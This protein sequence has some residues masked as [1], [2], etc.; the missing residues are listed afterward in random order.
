MPLQDPRLAITEMVR[1]V[2][3]LGLHGLAIGTVMG[4]AELDHPELLR[5]AWYH[6]GD[7]FRRDEDGNY[8]F[9]D[10]LRDVIR[11]HGENMS[12]MEI[13]REISAHPGVRQCAVFGVPGVGDEEVMAVIVPTD[14]LRSPLELIEFLVD[15]L[16][17]F[18]IPRY[19]DVADALPTT[20][21][22]RVQKGEL[23]ERGVTATTW[24]REAEGV[25][26][27]RPHLDT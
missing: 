5:N 10:R 26:L 19:I 18:M 21:T 11:R 25:F 13:E 7:A 1:A 16:P 15:R 27:R 12:T 24:D 14:A 2:D 4:G 17:H 23:R 20:Q 6:T 22:D 9:L 8:Y 3:E